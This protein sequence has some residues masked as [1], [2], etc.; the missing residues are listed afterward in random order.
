MGHSRKLVRQVVRGERTD[1]FRT[2]PSSLDKH[3]PFLEDQWS[4]GCRKGAE[5]WRR[6]R[7]EGFQGSLRVVGEWATRRRRAEKVS[8]QQLQKVPSARTIA[9]LLTTKRDHMSKADAVTIAAIEAGVPSLIEARTLV[10]RFQ[11]MIRTKNNVDLDP[12]I[13]EAKTSLVASF[14]TGIV[15]DK[16]AVRAA[17]TQPWSNGQ[18]EAQITKLKLVKRQ[19]YG[20]A[21]IDLLQAGLLGAA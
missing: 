7:A 11:A 3:L 9:R 18:V 4:K 19:M 17:I 15:K 2:R 13:A 14:V 10:D 5:L 21:K 6:L 1:V 12:W 16:A 8:N 20:R